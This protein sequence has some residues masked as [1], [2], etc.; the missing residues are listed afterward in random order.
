MGYSNKMHRNI[1]HNLLFVPVF[2]VGLL[3]QSF[4]QMDLRPGYIIKNSGD[5]IIG[6]IDFRGDRNN[7]KVCVFYQKADKRMELRPSEIYGYRF[8]DGEY[9]ISKY[10][11]RPDTIF[12]V[13]VEYLVQ[14]KKDLFYY[15]DLS[16]NHYLVNKTD[17]SLLEIPYSK[18]IINVD[19]KSYIHESTKHI[20]LLK[21]FF[22]DCPSVFSDIENI[23]IPDLNNLVSVT[24]KYHELMCE[25]DS[26]IVYRKQKMPLKIAFEPILQYTKFKDEP[27]IHKQYGCLF[28]IL[29]PETSEKIYLKSGF[30]HS[31]SPVE[32]SYYKIPFQFEYVYPYKYVQPKIDVGMNIFAFNDPLW[33][34][35]VGLT[36]AAGGGVRLRATKFLFV[37]IFL[38]SDVFRFSWEPDFVLSHSYGIG[39]VFLL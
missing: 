4:A 5:T 23:K 27:N 28:Y 26:C 31:D 9:F 16:G 20:G 35:V 6:M 18:R 29:L 2:V 3:S 21:M 12:Q 14:G 33:A 34:N 17:S 10:I 37:D 25:T 39:M 32:Y 24:K 13:F 19:G 1:L 15:R 38:E 22:S 7:C 8:D 36:F 11:V 30:M